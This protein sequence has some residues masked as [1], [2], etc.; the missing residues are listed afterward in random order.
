MGRGMHDSQQE[1][2]MKRAPHSRIKHED[3]CD[4]LN[5]KEMPK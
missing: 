2:K 3:R 5:E 1:V 4:L